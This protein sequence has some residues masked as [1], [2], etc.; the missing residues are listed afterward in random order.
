VEQTTPKAK[1]GSIFFTVFLDM[2]GIGL[3]IPVLAPLFLNPA[4]S[5]L[6]SSL[7]FGERTLVLGLLI[8]AYPLAQF[9][10]APILGALSDRWGRKP[11]LI[12]SLIGTLTGY[13]LFGI[14]IVYSSLSVLFLSRLLDGFTGGNISTAFSAIADVSDE[15][16]KVKNF[17]LVGMAFG[18]GF[19][20]GPY[21][22]GKLSD[23]S[24]ISWFS[25]ATPFWFAAGLASINIA[26]VLWR[27][28]ETLRVKV[29]SE[30]SLL[31]GFRN[32]QKAWAMQNLRTMFI[33]IF[34]LTFGFNFFTQFFQV[35]LVEKFNFTQSGIGDLFAYIG[36][37]IAFTQ[38]VLTRPI[39]KRFKP[40][41]V[42]KVSA[43][44][45][46]LSFPLLLL[47]TQAMWLFFIL[48]LISVF[49]GL[50]EPNSTAIVSN[51]AGADSQGEILGIKQ[52]IQSLAM[53]V[54]PIIAGSIIW[55]H[56]NLPTLIA[57]L[58]TLAAWIIFVSFF[59]HKKTELFHEV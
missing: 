49:Q 55:L 31:T 8:A 24:L 37:W 50:T 15:H 29:M 4:V 32:L 1:L 56:L 33:V 46:G 27:F 21:V 13:L 3:V 45:L 59:E 53:A 5:P 20:I 43:L 36:L 11:V 10:G 51:L 42:L 28:R 17:G 23:P 2:L 6:P 54:P 41:Q 12:F 14:G 19:I 44:C 39:G 26:L 47:P 52:S 9:F 58:S 18:L 57:G 16:N 38:G 34:L 22:G 35:F 25:Y 40:H 48:P 30:L 7:A